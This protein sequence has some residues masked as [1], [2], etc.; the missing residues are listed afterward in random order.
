MALTKTDNVI[1]RLITAPVVLSTSFQD[2]WNN[3]R[4]G[5]LIKPMDCTAIALWLKLDINDSLGFRVKMLAAQD[6]AATDFYVAP[7]KDVTAPVINVQPAEYR[8]TNNVDQ[9]LVITFPVSDQLPFVKF[10]VK[11][12]TLGVTPGQ[13]LAA[14]VSFTSNILGGD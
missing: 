13:V 4:G 9:N 5:P 1:Q 3:V 10:Q 14:G 7:I 12:D 11:V 8:F 2:L 6:E